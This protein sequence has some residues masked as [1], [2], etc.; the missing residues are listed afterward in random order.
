MLVD[1][2]DRQLD[3][4]VKHVVADA[5]GPVDDLADEPEVVVEHP[6]ED[7][8]GSAPGA[9][10]QPEATRRVEVH[11]AGRGEVVEATAER[12]KQDGAAP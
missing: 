9:G 10:G 6:V 4:L 8:H 11:P 2:L 3:G 5:R 7:I 1:P 12:R